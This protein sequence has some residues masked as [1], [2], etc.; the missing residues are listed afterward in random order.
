MHGNEDNL[1][2][3]FTMANQSYMEVTNDDE[4]LL[5]NVKLNP[6]KARSPRAIEAWRRMAQTSVAAP[7]IDNFWATLI[8]FI[9]SNILSILSLFIE[10]F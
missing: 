3:P 5:L 4:E 8:I 10:F 2:A 9:L 1:W 7:N 6:P